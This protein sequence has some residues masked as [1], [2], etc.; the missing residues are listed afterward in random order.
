MESGDEALKWDGCGIDIK[1]DEWKKTVSMR[2]KKQRG[3][4]GSKTF[5]RI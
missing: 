2:Q 3:N 1:E 5:R 4:H